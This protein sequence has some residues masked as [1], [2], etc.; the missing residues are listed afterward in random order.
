MATFRHRPQRYI[1]DF[2][3]LV[4]MIMIY[5]L[6]FD[7]DTP[8]ELVRV[9]RCKGLVPRF[10]SAG[11]MWEIEVPPVECTSVYTVVHITVSLGKN[12]TPNAIPKALLEP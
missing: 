9:S 11:H 3:T 2:V 1:R 6:F 12:T 7:T 5:D 8:F 10:N 4:T